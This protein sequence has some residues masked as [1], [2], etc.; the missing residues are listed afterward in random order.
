[1]M[2]SAHVKNAMTPR[3]EHTG[4]HQCLFLFCL[5]SSFPGDAG[6]MGSPPLLMV[7]EQIAHGTSPWMSGAMVPGCIATR[8]LPSQ[9]WNTASQQD[10]V[11]VSDH[12]QAPLPRLLHAQKRGHHVRELPSTPFSSAHQVGR[13]KGQVSCLKAAIDG[14]P[15]WDDGMPRKPLTPSSCPPPPVSRA[16]NKH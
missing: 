13:L 6:V 7:R 9:P 8:G 15:R 2:N 12:V 4:T 5:A 14:M 10:T 11:P 3:T 16:L 1:M